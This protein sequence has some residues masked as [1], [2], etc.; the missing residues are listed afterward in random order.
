MRVHVFGQVGERLLDL[1][2]REQAVKVLREGEK[3]AE[4]LSTSAF[5]GYSRG[6]FAEELAQIDLEAALKLCAGLSD[7]D[8]FN[9]HHGNMAHELAAIDPAA[10]ERVLGLMKKSA[11]NYIIP[12]REEKSV[13]VCYRMIRVDRPRAERLANS[14]TTLAIQA[15]AKGLMAQSLLEAQPSEQAAAKRLLVD[16]FKILDKAPRSRDSTYVYAPSTIAAA[17]LNVVEQVDPDHFDHYLWKT[18][19]LR[20]SPP[21]EGQNDS[22]DYDQL[23]M[24]LS[25]FDVEVATTVLDWIPKQQGQQGR[26]YLPARTILRPAEAVAEVERSQGRLTGRNRTLIAGYLTKTGPTLDRAIRENA[27]LWYPDVEDNGQ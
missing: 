23:S 4:Q 7:D 20:R 24:L 17:L 22:S 14:I 18:L 2:E 11:T 8:E 13:R 26:S 27:G 5:A 12:P 21:Q 10:A 1:G 19:V 15:Y 6:A 25:R 9:R 3:I 16:A